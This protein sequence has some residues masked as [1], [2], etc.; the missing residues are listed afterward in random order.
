MNPRMPRA[1][2]IRSLIAGRSEA[3]AADVWQTWGEDGRSWFSADTPEDI[4]TGLGRFGPPP[5]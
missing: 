2:S 4:E 3:I 1:D 5:G